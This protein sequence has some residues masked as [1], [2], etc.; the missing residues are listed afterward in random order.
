[1]KGTVR[2]DIQGNREDIFIQGHIC[3]TD[4]NKQYDISRDF[5]TAKKYFDDCL[6]I[7][8]HFY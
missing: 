3:S 5:E 4:I 2:Y 1:M 6:R 7:F 8:G